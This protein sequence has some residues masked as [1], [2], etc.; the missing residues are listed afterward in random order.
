MEWSGTA[1]RAGWLLS[2]DPVPGLSASLFHQPHIL[3]PHTPIDRLAHVVDR[4]QRDRYGGQRF[5]FHAGGADGL[6]GDFAVDGAGG[7]ADGELADPQ[8]RALVAINL[9]AV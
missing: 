1:P 2:S 3:D 8:E 9:P 5:H 6:G 7:I 4:Q